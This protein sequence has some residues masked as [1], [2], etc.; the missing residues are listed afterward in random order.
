MSRRVTNFDYE[1]YSADSG[2][3]SVRASTL[4]GRASG[5]GSGWCDGSWAQFHGHPFQSHQQRHTLD[6]M[7][8]FE[9]FYHGSRRP[10]MASIT[11]TGFFA[12]P[13][14]ASEERP[15]V[16]ELADRRVVRLRN[17]VFREARPTVQVKGGVLRVAA[18]A[19][20]KGEGQRGATVNEDRAFEYSAT[21]GPVY[22]VRRI[23]AS[24]SGDMLT[25]TIPRRK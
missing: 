9:P 13:A 25:L 14:Q 8:H 24:R 12:P 11:D 3:Q 10:H 16:E 22:D 15:V 7:A 2:F 19:A 4:P 1:I 17:A 21:L 23:A 18:R 20:R 5:Q 6:H